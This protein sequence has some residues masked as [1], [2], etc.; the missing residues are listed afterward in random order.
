MA[1]G[2]PDNGPAGRRGERGSDDGDAGVV[3]EL[4]YVAHS[5]NSL[6]GNVI[7]SGGADNQNSWPCGSDQPVGRD[8]T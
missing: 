3:F 2:L 7:P 4:V 1:I 5:V 8:R 6:Y